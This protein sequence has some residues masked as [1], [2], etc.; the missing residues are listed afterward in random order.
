MKKS[1]SGTKH[2]PATSKHPKGN[3][4]ERSKS[5]PRSSLIVLDFDHTVVDKNTDTFV[6]KLGENGTIPDSIK[7]SEKPWTELMQDVFDYLF[8]KGRTP[9]EILDCIASM[10]LAP[11]MQNLL[12][13]LPENNDI[14]IIS[15]SNAVF[16]QHIL[17]QQG[18]YDRITHIFTNPAN[19]E[20]RGRL[21]V[22]PYTEQEAC[23]LC[24]KNICKW[25]ALKSH[26]D[27]VYGTGKVYNRIM[28]MGDGKNDLCPCLKLSEN[29]TIFARSGFK[30]EDEI[31][32]I[33][34]AKKVKIAAEVIFYQDA[35]VMLEYL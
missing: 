28:Y 31:K 10:K 23:N 16:I 30:L 21:V 25:E 35:A 1:K 3:H 26:V 20:D 19:F 33:R 2:S 22:T 34:H 13:N 9:V 32:K 29:D 8:E 5:F 14:V 6:W 27:R 24:E 15:D 4:L 11:G 7:N 18:L 17:E 12:F